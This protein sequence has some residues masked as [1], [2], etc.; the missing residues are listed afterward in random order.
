MFYTSLHVDPNVDYPY[1]AGFADE[2]G[3]PGAPG[4]NLNVPLAAGCDE[5]R[6][7]DALD[8]ALGAVDAFAADVLVVSLGVDTHRDDPI[9]RFD[10]ATPAFVR[11]GERLAE[12]G[13]RP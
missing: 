5:A 11:I 2:V 13:S 9:G 4:A 6:Y 12:V 3:G 7:L 10:L 8:G 1:F